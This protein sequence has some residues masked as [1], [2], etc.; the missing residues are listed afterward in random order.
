MTTKTAVFST[1]VYPGV[2]SFT[3]NDMTSWAL[4]VRNTANN[5]LNG[6][7]NV[8]GNFTLNASTVSTS[9]KF[10]PGM[11]GPQTKMIWYPVTANAAVVAYDGNMF[12]STTDSSNSI[13]GLTHS[14]DANTDKTFAYVLIG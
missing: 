11:I 6:K 7:L 1:T 8:T 12:L 4:K 14:S 10:I 3:G 9:I 2:P 5:S 13:I